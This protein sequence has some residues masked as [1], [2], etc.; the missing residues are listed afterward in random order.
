MI[1]KGWDTMYRRK[2][3][4]LMIFISFL[5]FLFNV[6]VK[7][8]PDIKRISGDDRYKTSIQI[9]K[10]GWDKSDYVILASGENFPDALCAA[11]LA[12][13]YSAPILLTDKTSISQDIISELARLNVRNVI[14]IGGPTIISD[15]EKET[16]EKLGYS[17]RRIYGQNRYETSAKIASEFNNPKELAVVNGSN[18]PDGLS[19]S[20]VA[21]MKEMPILLVNSNNIDSSVLDCIK[22]KDIKSTY[23]VGG[24]GVVSDSILN[25]FNNPIRIWGNDRYDTNMKVFRQFF[26]DASLNSAYIASGEGFPDALACSALSAKNSKPL[27]LM[28]KTGSVEA[29]RYIY[30]NKDSI[31]KMTVIGGGGSIRPKIVNN[32]MDIPNKLID[33]LNSVGSSTQVIIVEASSF[34]TFH[35][36]ATAY[37]LIDGRWSEYVPTFD[38]V[39]GINGFSTSRHEGDKTTPVGAY[40]FPFLFGWNGNHGFK[41][42]FREAG[43]YDYWVSNTNWDEYN[44]WMT[45]KGDP[46]YRFADYELLSSQP[47]YKYAAATDFNYG[48]DKIYGKGSGIFMHIAPYSGGGTLGCVGM[49]EDRLLKILMWMDPAK[50][51]VIIMGPTSELNNM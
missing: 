31:E 30:S 19:I 38:C 1:F 22:G 18:Y 20:P 32:L 8:A 35:A 39:V 21:A 3:N 49:P 2:V 23:V 43:T 36:S 47:L 15:S 17:C 44:V 6:N 11:P 14:I 27:M 25:T 16:L 48:S 50:N 24:A 37:E 46:K 34:G 7:A 4:L 33:N 10:D 13:K 51:P 45:Y 12:K 9:C 26:N 42:P 5:I 29:Y 40:H 28:D 41:F